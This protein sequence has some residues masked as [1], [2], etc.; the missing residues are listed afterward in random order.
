MSTTIAPRGAGDEKA[1]PNLLFVDEVATEL[2][3]SV[4]SVRWFIYSKKLK[5]GKIGGRIVVR[6]ADLEKFIAD[7]FEEAS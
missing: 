6:R 5:A 3:R 4:D 1:P 7:A 2:R